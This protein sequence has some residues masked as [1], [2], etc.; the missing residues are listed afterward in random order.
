M[1]HAEAKAVV[2]EQVDE[3]LALF[4]DDM[5]PKKGAVIPPHVSRPS[6]RVSILFFKNIVL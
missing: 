6:P 1:E 4:D 5:R 2:R 3:W